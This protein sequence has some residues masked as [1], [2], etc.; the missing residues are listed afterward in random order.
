[1]RLR[2]GAPARGRSRTRA[3]CSARASLRADP[4]EPD[5]PIESSRPAAPARARG[6]AGASAGAAGLRCGAD[7]VLAVV[8]QELQLAGPA[9]SRWAAGRVSGPSRSAARATARASI[10]S[11]L[12]RLRSPRRLRP[13]ASGG[14]GPRARPRPTRKRSR[15]PET[16]RQS[17]IA[18]I[19]SLLEM[20]PQASSSAIARPS[21]AGAVSSPRELTGAPQ[22][23]PAGVGSLV[24]I[25]SDHDHVHS[26]LRL[27]VAYDGPPADEPHLGRCHAPIK[28]SRGSSGGGGRHNRWRSD[29]WVDS[30]Y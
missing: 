28:S 29:P 19:R 20:R 26:S 22:T 4:L 13:S 11:D 18:Q 15:A 1:M 21:L 2:I 17:S 10:G 30:H 16:W 9:S 24:G 12:P 3:S 7:E 25:R 23:P 27:V 14:P 6:R 8:E 5:R